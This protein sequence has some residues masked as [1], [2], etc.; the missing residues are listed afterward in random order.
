[1]NDRFTS[2]LEHTYVDFQ[3]TSEIVKDPLIFTRAEGIYLWDINGKRYY[4]AIS[5]IF[6]AVLGHRHPRV[7]AA[8]QSQMEKI[9]FSPPLH[10]TTEVYLRFIEKLGS[11]TPPNLSFIKSFSGG[12]ESIEAAMKFTRQYHKQ[13]GHPEKYKFISLYGGYHG[14]TFGALA[15]TGSARH[16]NKFEPHMSGFIKVFS[17]L[18]YRDVFSS[19]E[20]ANRFAANLIEDVIIQE[21]PETI[22]GFIIEP[23][24]NVSG[25]VTPTDEYFHIIREICTRHQVKMILDEIVTGFGRTGEM[26]AAQTFGV[27]PDII[28][29]GKGLSSGAVPMGAMIA[30][31]EMAEPFRGPAEDNVQFFHGHTYSGNPLS[32]AVGIAVIDELVE[33]Q[34]PQKA[35]IMGAYLNERLQEF[36]KYGVIREIRG[37]GL[38]RGIE[39]VQDTSTMEPFPTGRKL[40]DAMKKTAISNGLILRVQGDY[41]SVA[42]P[43]IVDKSDIDELIALLDKS[44]DEALALVS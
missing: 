12:S 20:E 36:R 1:M 17:P 14:G 44:L 42:P 13:S 8:M 4:D 27:I 24:S 15:A 10:G 28:C 34:L 40:G 6:V 9:T 43:L 35:R 22:A 37:K 7:M 2:L 32:A 38:L 31:H 25:V 16:K 39:F 19:W 3:Q 26:F 18:H 5:G 23:I 21:G 30:N 11:I 41:L 33:K 29:A